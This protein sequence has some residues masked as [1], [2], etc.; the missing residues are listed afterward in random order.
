MSV[1]EIQSRISAVNAEIARLNS[2]RNQN[3][4]RRE[5]LQK[6]LQDSI[7]TYRERFG[8]E[9][10]IDNLRAELE[11]V[12]QEKEKEVKRVEQILNLI[13]A[14]DIAEANRLAGVVEESTAGGIEQQ[15]VS[16]Q[17]NIPVPP[18]VPD[19][20]VSPSTPPVTPAP[21][22]YTSAE[23]SN[24]G[25]SALEGFTKPS[26]QGVSGAVPTSQP[27]MASP[28]MVTS[29]VP[30]KPPTPPTAPTPPTPTPPTP[31]TPP[32]GVKPKAPMDFGAIL[33]GTEF[34]I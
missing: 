31:P 16:A 6:Q 7:N 28:H 4:G 24:L 12:T 9:L 21:Q 8:V 1:T 14:G 30:P 18:V 13:K 5:G 19:I 25:M 10:N 32:S 33:N 34:K 2:Q 15:G 22:T 26:V 29:P 23:S 3:I 17:A 11:K 27:Q 20:P